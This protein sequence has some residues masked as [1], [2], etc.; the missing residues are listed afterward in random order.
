[1]QRLA[2][3]VTFQVLVL[4]VGKNEFSCNVDTVNRHSEQAGGANVGE[5]G[6]VPVEGVAA[7]QRDVGREGNAC[8]RRD[9]CRGLAAR[10]GDLSCHGLRVKVQNSSPSPDP[11]IPCNPYLGK[12]LLRYLHRGIRK[13]GG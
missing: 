3:C 2:Q 1:M 13:N 11:A 5:D 4:V 6:N 7:T 10:Q 8:Q 9:P 12:L